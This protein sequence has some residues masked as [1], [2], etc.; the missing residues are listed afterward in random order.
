MNF[1][2][3]FYKM[4]KLLSMHL[5]LTLLVMSF[6][7]CGLFSGD[8]Q[9]PGDSNAIGEIKEQYPEWTQ[10]TLEG[11]ITRES[12]AEM[13]YAGPFYFGSFDGLDPDSIT[14]P[15]QR[16]EK[17]D[18]IIE[19]L[20]NGI[21]FMM[22]LDKKIRDERDAFA[23]YIAAI[24][25][26]DGS[27]S[28]YLETIY[29]QSGINLLSANLSLLVS[30]KTEADDMGKSS[31]WGYLQYQKYFSFVELIDL[32]AVEQG[33]LMAQTVNLYYLLESD[34]NTAYQDLNKEFIAKIDPLSEESS[35]LLNQLY[36]TAAVVNFGKD[37]LF[38]ADYYFAKD[39]VAAIDERIAQAKKSIEEYNGSKEYLSPEMIE[40]LKGEVQ[41]LEDY[42]NNITAY[43]ESIPEDALLTEE[44]LKGGDSEEVSLL[45]SVASAD[46]LPGWFQEKVGEAIK[47]VK[48][49]K[50]ISCAAVRVTGKAVKDYYDTSGAHEVVKDGAQILNGGLE[51]VNSGVEV[52]IKNAQDIYWGD[53]S[54][55]NF[56]KSIENEKNELHDKF[57]KGTLGKEQY[58]EMINQIDQ[59]QKNTNTLIKNMS[60]FSG[61]V[62]TVVTKSSDAGKFVTTV[63][64]NVANEAKG[65]L[66]TATDFS[67]NLAII[68]HPET[69]K[70]ETRNALLGIYT[71]LQKVKNDKGEYEEVEIP[72]LIEL[73]KGE[74][75]KEL[76]LT[77]EEEEEFTD[78]LKD[79]FKDE[80]KAAES[81]DGA[82]K[83]DA[84]D[85][86]KPTDPKAD[87]TKPTDPKGDGTETTDPEGDETGTTDPKGDE[88]GTID[89]KSDFYEKLADPNITDEQV[90]DLIIKEITR[91]LPPLKGDK[92]D[93][94]EEEKEDTD[95]DG[96]LDIED[97]CDEDS[98]P[99]QAN[100]DGDSMGDDCDP[101]C[102]GDVDGDGICNELDNC[103]QQP[104][105]DQADIDKDL[106]GNVCDEDA[107]LISELT[108][109]WPGTIK[110]TE[111]YIE[112][113]F[114]AKAGEE[115]CD[116]EEV[117]KT[118]D[119]V[120]PVTVTITPT[121]ETG[122]TLLLGVEGD[123][124]QS[125]PFTYV[126]GKL[127]ASIVQDEA[128]INFNMD[129][130][131]NTTTGSMDL[132]YLGGSIKLK[133][134]V[135]LEKK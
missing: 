24:V 127:T 128:S 52:S 132:D 43:L 8:P 95:G 116:V 7:G 118:K 122:G 75:A 5:A 110:V 60:E 59:F 124:S 70:E 90:T 3:F 35:E 16:N 125:I 76:G 22:D 84:K 86:S 117:E 135:N 1:L 46:D 53:F 99:D 81:K 65:A 77:E 113:E 96:V 23:W 20:D 40:L 134:E 37:L 121:S 93:K 67:K 104:N 9:G 73:T 15:E 69:S 34:P 107:P 19:E 25:E 2:I 29:G 101:D 79:M 119:Q 100:T 36:H 18:E 129:F 56:K 10:E 72:D 39:N 58:T 14:Y 74:A 51:I 89:P 45:F 112:P 87:G 130:S 30:L 4:K 126:D 6:S 123:E 48:F 49:V 82:K 66:D 102:S 21:N 83:D 115:G 41:D 27:T 133:A 68:M 54:W 32:Y 61:F 42:R 63:T 55:K 26:I 57:V 105:A 103:P 97:N 31:A 50:A 80:L 17:A 111:V 28:N 85:D 88:T 78:K 106:I 47:T 94:D 98:N 92:K 71:T 64:K 12:D 44:D 33:D 13:T 91:G 11:F 62:T 131:R 108:G 109:S 114:R 120:K 38:T